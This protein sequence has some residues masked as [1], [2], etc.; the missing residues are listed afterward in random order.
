MLQRVHGSRAK[1]LH[2]Y[3]FIDDVSDLSAQG[4][5]QT[6]TQS[7]RKDKTGTNVNE[8]NLTMDSRIWSLHFN[9][10]QVSADGY[11]TGDPVCFAWNNRRKPPARDKHRSG[12]VRMSVSAVP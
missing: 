8:S 7:E 10:E 11:V 3:P 12:L 6:L 2:I 1:K 9:K 5:C 4:R